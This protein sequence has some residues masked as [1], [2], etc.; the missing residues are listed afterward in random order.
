[1]GGALCL[2]AVGRGGMFAFLSGKVALLVGLGTVT[3]L[4]GVSGGG[5]AI[6]THTSILAVATHAIVVHI[7]GPRLQ[8]A[9]QA[10]ESV[11]TRTPLGYRKF[12]QIRIRQ[13]CARS[14]IQTL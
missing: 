6:D 8:L 12:Q 7:A 9:H 2:V 5:F 4:D 11:W 14:P 1:M 10:R 3:F 13:H